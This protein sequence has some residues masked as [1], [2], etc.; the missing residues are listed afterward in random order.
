VDETGTL[1]AGHW[2]RLGVLA[3]VALGKP[4]SEAAAHVVAQLQEDLLPLQTALSP[5]E[6][7]LAALVLI[8]YAFAVSRFEQFDYLSNL[9]EHPALFE[10]AASLLRARWVFVSGFAHYQV[11]HTDRAEREWRR[12]LALARESDH[13]SLALKVTLAMVR[14]WLD[15]GRVDE[16]DRMLETLDPRWGAGRTAMLIELQQM[17]AR[18][19]VLRGQPARALVTLQEANQL[20]AKVGLSRSESAAR[21]T[22][23]AQIYIALNRSDEALALLIEERVV[24]QTGAAAERASCLVHLLRAWMTRFSDP[25]R[26]R[27]DLERGLEL[28]HAA[29]YT[30]YFRLLPALAAAVSAYALQTLK[31]SENGLALQFVDDVIRI[32]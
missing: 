13:G 32:R 9:V 27:Q 22:D 21:Q 19:Q 25:Q 15:R 10:A 23:L 29:S 2:L 6:R 28:A 31:T 30:M 26:S 17:R 20:A 11:S 7:L 18:V 16:A 1:M 4:D 14:L 3:R 5:N 8:E 12:A 24:A